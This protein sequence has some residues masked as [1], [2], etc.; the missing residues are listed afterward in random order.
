MLE[1]FP[2]IPSR[3]RPSFEKSLVMLVFHVLIRTYVDSTGR[4]R[5]CVLCV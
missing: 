1:Y 2:E 3:Q 4:G 5:M